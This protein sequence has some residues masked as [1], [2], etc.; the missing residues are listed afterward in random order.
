MP[1]S[2]EE[3]EWTIRHAK[4]HQDRPWNSLEP[5]GVTPGPLGFGIDLKRP[6]GEGL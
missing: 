5:E 1:L 3:K 6:R 2:I 4:P